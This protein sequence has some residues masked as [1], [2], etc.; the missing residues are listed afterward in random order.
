MVS[1]RSGAKFLHI[2]LTVITTIN[3]GNRTTQ[4]LWFWVLSVTSVG[5]KVEHKKLNILYIHTFTHKSIRTCMHACMHTYIHCLYFYAE[6]VY[7]FWT[8]E[9]EYLCALPDRMTKFCKWMYFPLRIV[10]IFISAVYS[11]VWEKFSAEVHNIATGSW[12][13]HAGVLLEES[14]FLESVLWLM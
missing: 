10:K 11:Q 4:F 6:L 13:E 9:A 14:C 8:G 5:G 1:W 7:L 2:I 12:S 3:F